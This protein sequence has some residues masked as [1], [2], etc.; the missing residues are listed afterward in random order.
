MTDV[1]RAFWIDL[2]AMAGRSRYPGRICAGLTDGVFVG[3]PLNKF[4]ALMAQPID[5]EQTLALFERTGKIKLTV[6]TES[7]TKLVMLEL[8]N[9]NKYQS[10]YQRQKKYR[11]R[12]LH[13]GDSGGYNRG[14]KTEGEVEGEVEVEGDGEEAPATAYSSIGF[15]KPFGHA[16]F[17]KIWEEEFAKP[18]KWLTEKMETTIQRCQK[19]KVG[20]PPQFYDAKHDVEQRETKSLTKVPW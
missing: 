8:L 9:W 16:R 18:A 1:Q 3:Y 14:N 6:T 5:V 19:L 4:Q 2:L 7:P 13:K 17:Q 10:E 11:K 15:D 20:I 12:G